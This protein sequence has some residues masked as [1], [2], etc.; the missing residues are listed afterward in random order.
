MVDGAFSVKEAF[1]DIIT[2]TVI[3]NVNNEIRT[4]ATDI[5]GQLTTTDK[6]AVSQNVWGKFL[7]TFRGWLQNAVQVRLKSKGE[8]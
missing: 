3:S 2:P 5:D 8:N 6:A 4:I 1:K 7:V